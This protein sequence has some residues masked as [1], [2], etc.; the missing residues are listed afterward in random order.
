MTTKKPR[1]TGAATNAGAPTPVPQLPFELTAEEMALAVRFFSACR[2]MD[3]GHRRAC[4]K[5]IDV[6]E[7]MAEKY[8]AR[9]PSVLRL[10]VGG[11]K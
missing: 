8:R 2:R 1:S 4:M 9:P 7:H 10:V 5:S 11:A 3:D 6:A